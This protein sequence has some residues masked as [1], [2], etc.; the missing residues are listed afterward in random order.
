MYIWWWINWSETRSVVPVTHRCA[1]SSFVRLDMAY[2]CTRFYLKSCTQWRVFTIVAPNRIYK[3]NK[4][5]SLL[6]FIWSNILKF[7]EGTKSIPFCLKC[8]ICRPLD[9][10]PRGSPP[11]FSPPPPPPGI[12]LI[13]QAS[14][15]FTCPKRRNYSVRWSSRQLSGHWHN[16]RIVSWI[17]A[18]RSLLLRIFTLRCATLR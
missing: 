14:F 9:S 4:L 11:P 18:L 8:L 13:L 17:S 5:L 16:M 6:K 3:L 2:G 10:V 1:D 12:L 15:P 7:V